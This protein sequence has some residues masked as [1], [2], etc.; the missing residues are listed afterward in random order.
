[1]EAYFISNGMY[2]TTN[3]NLLQ[4]Q[5]KRKALGNTQ[6]SRVEQRR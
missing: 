1:M 3:N 5:N 4:V 6:D 2:V